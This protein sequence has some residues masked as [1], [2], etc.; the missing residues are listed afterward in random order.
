LKLAFNGA[1]EMALMDDLAGNYREF[2]ET[3]YS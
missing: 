3:Q 2:A 1:P